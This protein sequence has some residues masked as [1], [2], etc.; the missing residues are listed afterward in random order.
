M[1]RHG[2]RHVDQVPAEV[3]RVPLAAGEWWR[4]HGEAKQEACRSSA[5]RGSASSSSRGRKGVEDKGG[6]W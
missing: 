5:R 4:R 1:A 6:I 3:E 2:L